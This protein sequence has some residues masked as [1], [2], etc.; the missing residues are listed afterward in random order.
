MCAV[1]F[2]SVWLLL[3]A[4]GCSYFHDLHS[5]DRFQDGYT[6][7]LPGIE[8]ASFANSNIAQGLQNGG[9]STAIEV[10]DWTTG[11]PAFLLYHLRNFDRNQREAQKLADKIVAYQDRYP[12]KPVYLIGHSGGGGLTLLTLEA[13]P[14]DRRITAAIL[15]APAISPTYDLTTALSKTEA[16]I[17][18]YHS[19]MDAI[20]LIAGTTIAGTIDGKH[21]P[22]AGAFGFSQPDELSS[23]N[24]VLYDTKLHQIS[25]DF[26]MATHGNLGGHFG[27]TWHQFATDYLAPILRDPFDQEADEENAPPQ[28]GFARIR[29]DY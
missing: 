17:W 16:G 20:L 1:R 11:N 28:A 22:A 5:L 7:V 15:L 23:E 4:S 6:L 24:R 21:T 27:A 12:G 2:C 18:N 13:L 9:V 25:Y 14:E 19:P 26:A 10:H 8:T 29:G 3:A